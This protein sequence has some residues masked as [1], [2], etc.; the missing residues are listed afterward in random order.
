[1]SDYY[2]IISSQLVN[3]RVLD[4]MVESERNTRKKAQWAADA[5]LSQ[6]VAGLRILLEAMQDS[7]G[8]VF[9]YSQGTFCVRKTQHRIWRNAGYP[10][11]QCVRPDGLIC[12]FGR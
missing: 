6:G 3:M 8:C 9:V 10:L 11:K 1:M 2:Y 12:A 4:R 7:L 5:A